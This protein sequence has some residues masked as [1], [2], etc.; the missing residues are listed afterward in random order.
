MAKT[1]AAPCGFSSTMSDERKTLYID[2]AKCIGCE[3][4]EAVCRFIYERPRI[5]MTCTAEGIA[6]P[7]YC[8]HCE[9]PKCANA[10]PRGALTKDAEGAVIL[11][12]LLCRGCE[13]RNCVI[14]CPYSAM[15]LT[16]T[17]VTVTKCDLCITRRAV[18]LGPACVET[19]PAEAILYVQRGRL[20]EL[21]TPEA[22]EA[23]K[24]VLAHV[25]P[26]AGPKPPR[27]GE[28]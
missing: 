13:T 9:N 23:E 20:A 5:H 3:T 28:A 14:A 16:E 15:L 8:R 7:L 27:G 21:V 6:A 12:Q 18:G 25:R 19:C 1:H 24:R 4:C 11:Q 2:Y 10:C 26:T 17:G 22:A